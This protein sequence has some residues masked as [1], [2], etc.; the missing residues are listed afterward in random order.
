LDAGVLLETKLHPPRVREEWVHRTELVQYLAASTAKLVLVDAPAGFGKSTLAAQWRAFPGQSRKFAWVSVDAGDNDAARLW[1][2]IGWALQRACP[3]LHVGE[4]LR[5]LGRP[6]ADLRG[7]LLPTLVNELAELASPVAL[8][9]DDYHLISNRDCHDQLEFVLLHLPPMVQMVLITRVD[10]PLPLGRLR[11]VGDLLEIR[12]P[13]LRFVAAE[14]A[15][16]VRAVSAVELDE[17]DLADLV[18]RT[19]GWPAGI[20]LAALSLRGQ[21]SPS[22]VIRQFTGDNRFVG[23]FLAQEVLSRQPGE[24]RDFLCRTAILDRFA[25]SLCDA[26]VGSADATEI[27]DILERENLF[28]VALDDDRQWFRYHQLFGQMLLSRL[29][30][31]EP[32]LVPVLHRRA[33]EWHQRWGSVEEAIV[34]ALAGGDIAGAIDVVARNWTSCIDT[35]RMRTL[36]A[37]LDSIGDDRIRASPVAAH[38]AAWCAALFGE[39]DSA[40][41]WLSVVE[42]AESDEPLPDG[43]PSLEFSA[44][45]L[46]GVFGFDSIRAMRESA[47]AAAELDTDPASPWYALARTALGAALCLSGEFDA[48]FAQLSD[49]LQGDASIVL[50]RL[51]ACSVM[52]LVAVEQGRVGQAQELVAAVRE[53]AGEG[54]DDLGDAPRSAI[55]Y[56]AVGAVAATQGHLKEARG[57]FEHA[58][59]AGR[60]C[61]GISP[62]VALDTMLRLAPVLYDLGD[63]AGAVGL[64]GEARAVLASRP[65]G[66]KAQLIR[67]EQLAKRFASRQRPQLLAEPLTDRE[68]EVLRLLQGTLSLREIGQELFL[69]ANT[70][71][72][73]ARAIY[74]KLGVS[75]RQ[76]AVE[77]GH[78]MGIL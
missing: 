32:D 66:A 31:T 18:R 46:R 4:F 12:V 36:R 63:Q 41:R 76:E 14:A 45:L 27:I 21:P 65:D 77:R 51:L 13:E 67:A 23:D 44:A 3:E 73:H 59:R 38:C 52:A 15:A 72:T 20:Y 74:R 61:S 56:T 42:A 5:Q 57:Y 62:W 68:E 8:V 24:I 40:R 17:T 54:E 26:V 10:P 39:Q 19:E 43:M 16:L 55:A 30:Q 48:A 11:A 29:V 37:W 60:R 9:L 58:L 28:L 75:T 6:G 69:S 78:Q 25:P 50:V 71:K 2:Y 7:S 47:A 70:I 1:R 35:A 34:H 64:L 53:I 33:S 22:S 49:A